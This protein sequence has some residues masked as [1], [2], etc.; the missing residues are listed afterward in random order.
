M[1]DKLFICQESSN[2]LKRKIKNIKIF[3]GYKYF[4]YFN[5]IKKFNTYKGNN[6]IIALGGGDYFDS[7]SVILNALINSK[8]NLF[9]FM[10]NE[11]TI[12]K[13]K[14]SK[15]YKIK[16]FN[17]IFNRPNI[18]KAIPVNTIRFGI[19]N[20]GYNKI[21]F[22]IHSIPILILATRFHQIDISKKFCY[23]YKSIY[24]GY[25]KTIKFEN[26]QKSINQMSKYPISKQEKL[27]LNKKLLIDSIIKY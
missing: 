7:Y 8:L 20:G 6:V 12:V 19:V 25:I 21:I 3:Y 22:N 23:K 17:F 15:F 13:I 26:I 10:N 18:M 4:P 11:N 1:A 2:F 9:I 5:K 27:I 16:H 24:M 14:K